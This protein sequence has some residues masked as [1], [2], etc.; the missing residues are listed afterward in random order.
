MKY[1]ILAAVFF[2]PLLAGENPTIVHPQ[3]PRSWRSISQEKPSVEKNP[4]PESAQ[5]AVKSKSEEEAESFFGSI[6]N[7]LAN[8]GQQIPS[9]NELSDSAKNGVA[10]VIYISTSVSVCL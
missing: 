8:F 7:G 4:T 5:V 6:Q 10:T 2:V 9:W 1:L 3:P